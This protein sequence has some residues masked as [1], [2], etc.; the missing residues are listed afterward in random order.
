MWF[1]AFFGEKYP[2]WGWKIIENHRIVATIGAPMPENNFKIWENGSKVYAHHFGYVEAEWKKNFTTAFTLCIVDV[3]P[4]VANSLQ[5]ATKTVKF[6]D[7]VPKTEGSTT[8]CAH[9]NAIKPCNLKK[10]FR[11]LF[12]EDDW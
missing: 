9:R 1:A 6:V 8:I 7:V 10:M 11:R 3:H 2:F 5:G 4:Y 12:I